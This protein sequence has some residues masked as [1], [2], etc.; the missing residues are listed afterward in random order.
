MPIRRGVFGGAVNLLPTA[1]IGA[2]TNFT[3][4]R[5]VFNAT[6]DRKSVV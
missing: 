4:S 3:E 2:T 1:T 6:I 5:G